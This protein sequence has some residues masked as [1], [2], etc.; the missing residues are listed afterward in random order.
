MSGE[1]LQDGL[2][3]ASSE[4]RPRPVTSHSRLEPGQI[5]PPSLYGVPS[6]LENM[7]SSSSSTGLWGQ[8]ENVREG[9]SAGH[10][11]HE[12]SLIDILHTRPERTTRVLAN[13]W[14]QV[15]AYGTQADTA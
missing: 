3:P 13:Q 10:T 15:P 7:A 9:L 14:E 11:V 1:G 2:S 8:V 4:G 12:T 5:T 6:N